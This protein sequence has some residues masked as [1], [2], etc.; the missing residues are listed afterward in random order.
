MGDEWGGNRW[1]EAKTSRERVV[2]GENEWW[3]AKRV[4]E[5]SER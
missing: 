5:G 4:G 3:E 1:W 2:G